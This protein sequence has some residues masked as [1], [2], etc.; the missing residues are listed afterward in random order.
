[1]NGNQTDLMSN[2]RR[3][4][5]VFDFFWVCSESGCLSLVRA[6][7]SGTGGAWTVAP[8]PHLLYEKRR[9]R[10]HKGEEGESSVMAA[11]DSGQEIDLYADNFEEEFN[12]VRIW[13]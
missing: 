2:I 6:P 11:T 13:Q 9:L 4:A 1:M 12:Q 10:Q 7:P 5:V 3:E 8:F